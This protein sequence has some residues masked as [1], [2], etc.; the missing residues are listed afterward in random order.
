MTLAQMPLDLWAEGSSGP[1]E[2]LEKFPH[3]FVQCQ[4]QILSIKNLKI[5]IKEIVDCIF[6]EN[7]MLDWDH[8]EIVE[9]QTCKA[10]LWKSTTL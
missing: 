7:H 8:P 6:D 5:F 10:N 9:R 4:L 2:S 1:L 3:Y